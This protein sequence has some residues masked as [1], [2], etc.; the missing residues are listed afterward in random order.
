[1]SA[2]SALPRRERLFLIVGMLSAALLAW[3]YLFYD[4][5]RM[6]TGMSCTCAG[7]TAIP[8]LF[9]M[10]SVMMIAMMLPSALPM[11]L[12]F[13]GLNRIRRQHG[14]PYVPVIIFVS[15]Y[16]AVWFVF[17]AGAALT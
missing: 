6:N 7:T 14:R 4:A 3:L 9:L 13:A 11:V 8:P 1:M 12:T 2:V 16:L 15:G 10:W 5:R 17:S